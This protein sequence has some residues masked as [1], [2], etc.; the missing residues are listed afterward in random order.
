MSTRFLK[1]CLIFA[2]WNLLS[3]CSGEALEEVTAT[4]GVR[5]EQSLTPPASQD[6]QGRDFWLTFPRNY[7]DTPALTLFIT[8]Q[9]STTGT[10]QIPGT[11]FSASFTVT[12][13]QVTPVSL[14]SSSQ[15]LAADGVENKGIHITAQE[16]VV[17]YGL[18]RIP[19][20]TDAYLGLPTDILGTDYLVL[21]YKNTNIINGTQLAIV[22]TQNDTAVTITPAVQAGSHPAGVPF[23]LTLNQG[24]A[25]QLQSTMS[26]PADLSGSVITSTKPIAVFGSHQ[27]ANI[28]E[29]NTFA[30][31]Y[32][33]EQLPPTSTWGKSFVTVP[34]ATRTRGDTFRFLAARNG[35]EVRIN[36]SLVATLNRGQ[37]YQT[38][39]ATQAH[40]T[41]N[42]PILVAQYSNGT[43]YDNVT[44]DPFMML[45][46]PYEQFLASYTVTT[47][48]SGFVPNYI[49]VAVPNAAVGQIRLDGVAVPSSAFTA[50]G[51]S[52]FSGAQLNVS[53]G[54]HTLTGPLPF[55]AFM[56]GFGPADSYGY[57]GGMSLAPISTVTSVTVA[58]RT[59]SAQVN[60]QHCLTATVLDQFNEPVNGVR[61]DW[62]VSGAN[63]V[64]GFANTDAEGHAPFCYTGLQSGADA[65]VASVGTLSDNASMS[66]QAL[67]TNHAPVARCQNVT[68]GA[69]CGGVA[70][71]VDNGSY[72]PDVDD[73]FSC[74]QSPGGPYRPGTHQV[75]LTCTDAAGDSSS[76]QATVTVALEGSGTTETELVLNGDSTMQL[77]C[78]VDTWV[79][80]GAT[81]TD[82]CGSSLRVLKFNSGD[83]D[84]DG[85]PG[86]QDPDDYGPG[87]DT[88]AEGTYSV[89][90]MAIDV[91]GYTVS[92]I[93]SVRVEDTRAPTLSLRGPAQM[94]HTCGSQ[95]VDPGV[96][97]RDACYGDVSPT[98]QRSGYVNGWVAGTYTV[99]YSVTDSG[100][101]SAPPVTRT[102]QVSN[103][104]W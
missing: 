95:W 81:A 16:D 87:P 5:I 19:A 82:M 84:E 70:V 90:Y 13:G 38:N 77:E 39:L 60:S 28:P 72:D 73:T 68:V 41:S 53:L 58:P 25:Y 96:D 33:V 26:A 6:S 27:C 46:P 40:I 7:F 37:L 4:A 22:A 89:Q 100:G 94:T 92:A 30:C 50:I 104:P 11:G 45:I 80:P 15:L 63:T 36:G 49:N 55:G 21:T 61:V 103:C 59:G 74:V 17:V 64:A 51:S 79:D 88:S 32:I 24:Q 71:S 48:Q 35:T 1:T 29:G 97:A 47:P 62:A 67:P 43:T 91:T 44:S 34:L 85:I 42:E 8:G 65:I 2:V 66:W 3:G 12:P 69:T 76:C 93:R 10:V 20:T 52:G 101:N 86:E 98:V 99:V 102:V 56:Y 54:T 78:G 75:T 9:T 23:T 31:D 83:D 57:P 18:S 14:P